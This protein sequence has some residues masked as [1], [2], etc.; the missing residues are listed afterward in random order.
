VP[1]NTLSSHGH[2]WV[3]SMSCLRSMPTKKI[4][5][6]PEELIITDPFIAPYTHRHPS[7]PT[8]VP[9]LPGRRT[10]DASSQAP[11]ALQNLQKVVLSGSATDSQMRVTE[12]HIECP[13]GQRRQTLCQKRSR[14]G[15]R[16]PRSVPHGVAQKQVGRQKFA[17]Q[18][19]GRD[20]ALVSP[21]CCRMCWRTRH[22]MITASGSTFGRRSIR[23][24]LLVS[25]GT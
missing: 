5:H 18:D 3:I 25:L 19:A 17:P 11:P 23:F 6:D 9:R 1:S 15:N 2:G 14:F 21:V 13:A 20:V 24:L 4:H 12:I 8:C 7:L 10:P 22:G 16:H